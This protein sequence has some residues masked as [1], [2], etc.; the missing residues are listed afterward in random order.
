MI[1]TKHEV[2]LGNGTVLTF[3]QTMVADTMAFRQEF[4][5]GV[6][7]LDVHREEFELC[8]ER[9][10]SV[11]GELAEFELEHGGNPEGL[12]AQVVQ[13]NLAQLD[14]ETREA[15]L[16]LR[17]KFRELRLELDAKKS[18]L[19][20]MSVW[21]A[22]KCASRGGF[23]GDFEQFLGVIPSTGGMLATVI[24]AATEAMTSSG[25]S[26]PSSESSG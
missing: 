24:A 5:F 11:Q 7:T 13:E 17:K 21:I 1:M 8:G 16:E 20:R 26:S 4:G 19:D 18:D 3:G 10:L 22:W 23:E 9:F 6:S 14:G 12:G 25:G 15:H 2:D